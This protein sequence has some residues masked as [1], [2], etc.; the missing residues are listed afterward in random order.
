MMLARVEG[1]PIPLAFIK[2][3]NSSSSTSLP[4]VSMERSK[5][6][7]VKFLGALVSFSKNEGLWVPDSPLTNVGIVFSSAS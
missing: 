2:S 3:L 7:S 5:V 1:L 6:A 4:A